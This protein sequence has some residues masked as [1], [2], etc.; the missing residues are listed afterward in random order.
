MAS[1]KYI[2]DSIESDSKSPVY[3]VTTNS[4]PNLISGQTYGIFSRSTF[5]ILYSFAAVGTNLAT[6]DVENMN[7]IMPFTGIII[8]HPVFTSNTGEHFFV[9]REDGDFGRIHLIFNPA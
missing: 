9:S 2:I 4:T 6:Y 3:L 5:P 8:K 1:F 7:A